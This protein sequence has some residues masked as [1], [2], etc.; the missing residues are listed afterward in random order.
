MKKEKKNSGCLLKTLIIL[1]L[2]FGIIISGVYAF[3][4]LT[5]E[6]VNEYIPSDYT[7]Y[8]KLDSI[9]DFYD[10]LVDLR[11]SDV[12]LTQSNFKDIYRY[13]LDIRS[14]RVLRNK[15]LMRLMNLKANI[16]LKNN[17]DGI[18][19][20][21]L[22][23]KSMLLRTS[24]IFTKLLKG[25]DNFTLDK[26]E[27]KEKRYVI[28]KLF[29]KKYRQTIYF[30]ICKNLLFVAQ[31]AGDIDYLYN[32]RENKDNLEKDNYFA[33][34][35]NK[36]KRGGIADIY[37]NT[38]ELIYPLM[39]NVSGSQ[40]ILSKLKFYSNS[41]A[42]LDISN[43]EIFLNT[44]TMYNVLDN[45]LL[46]FIWNESRSLDVIKYLPDNTNLYTA[47]SVRSFEE[48]YKLFL[49]LNEGQYDKTI[50]LID[51]A[52]KIFFKI[53]V[54]EIVFSWI[55]TELGIFS[56][57]I[58]SSP[59]AFLKIKDKKKLDFVIDKLVKSIVFEGDDSL[60][61]DN[62]KLSKISFPDF[63]IPLINT[64]VKNLDTPY[65]IIIDDYIYFSMDPASLANLA[66]KYDNKSTLNM[67]PTYKAVT[68]K[69]KDKANLFLYF[70]MQEKMP[71]YLKANKFV[72]DLLKLYEK[73]VAS[74][75]FNETKLEIDLAA[76]GVN[77]SKVKP[78]PGY[79]KRVDSNIT[80]EILCENLT[81]SRVEEII[82]TTADNKLYVTD[83]NNETLTGFPVNIQE[84]CKGQP[85]VARLSDR[86]DDA[87][88]IF[89]EKGNL[90]E[91]DREGV[92][93]SPYPLNTGLG[94]SFYPV[95]YNNDK[96]VFYS[97][98]DKRLVLFR[99]NHFEEIDF[100]LKSPVLSP[101]TIYGDVFAVYPKSFSGTIY[102]TGESGKILGGWPQEAGGL[103]YGSPLIEK[104]GKDISKSVIFLT[105]SG[106]LNAWKFD[107][108]A[109]SGF[110]IEI[111]GV[112][113]TQPSI[114]NVT[115]DG[116]NEF[117]TLSKD[118]TLTIISSA[119]KII[120]QKKYKEI[121]SKENRVLL[122]D[123]DRDGKAEIFIYGASDSIFGFDEKL[124]IMPGFPVSGATKPDFADFDSDGQIEMVTGG[125]DKYL[126]IYTIPR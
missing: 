93:T 87:I 1:V 111:D 99:D 119:G 10:S 110:P 68:S 74:I 84:E 25:N 27:N 57:N 45:K 82:Y 60:V 107:G 54:D 79:P 29:L 106:T 18:L 4:R 125:L 9:M 95:L 105:Q 13:L 24:Q 89:T 15:Y 43:E 94:G 113:Y 12:V 52:C 41:A 5:R 122:F 98:K 67:D 38:N 50:A 8:I 114:G 80:S 104:I 17:Y 81:G 126:Y 66:N 72:Y 118:G 61:Y 42:S 2:F 112:Y 124:D 21:D 33:L 71:P 62:V 116:E 100:E 63:L 58:S 78:F 35:K 49:Y 73:G 3:Y 103:G 70:N 96:L 92:Q 23:I 64:F 47:V 6:N 115:G 117:V 20:F 19:L 101:V 46:D 40:K 37:F 22:G 109:L 88:Y 69:V 75:E 56:S 51:K 11:A 120:L 55:G 16:V 90:Y 32:A 85:I 44:Y 77:I 7:L 108:N 86:V 91:F 48:F 65:Y 121:A 123:V 30:S 59:V 34:I 76:A 26:L 83:I 39:K 102:L 36:T 14:S 31:S 28:N 97:A 53:G